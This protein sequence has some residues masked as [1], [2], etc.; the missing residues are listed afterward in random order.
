MMLEGMSSGDVV[1]PPQ[2]HYYGQLQ[3]YIQQS[4]KL[5]LS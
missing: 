2:Q 1:Q 4:Q 3:Y 5:L